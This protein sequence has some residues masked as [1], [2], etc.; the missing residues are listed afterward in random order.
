MKKNWIPACA[1]MTK[2]KNGNDEGLM[3]QAPT[4]RPPQELPHFLLQ[5]LVQLVQERLGVEP[6]LVGAD[7]EIVVVARAW[8]GLFRQGAKITKSTE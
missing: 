7:E 1:G 3:P 8:R 6:C 4:R 5:I 2:R